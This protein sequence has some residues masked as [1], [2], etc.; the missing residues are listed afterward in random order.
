VQQGIPAQPQFLQQRVQ[1]L[2]R[3]D[4]TQATDEV[5][6]RVAVRVQVRS[7]ELVVLVDEG[8]GLPHRFA[9]GLAGRDVQDTMVADTLVGD[10]DDFLAARRRTAS[11]R[12]TVGHTQRPSNWTRTCSDTAS[13]CTVS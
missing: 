10:F 4:R 11:H 13:T 6:Q 7:E 3:I 5:R 1:R 9:G 12:I 2:H 8:R